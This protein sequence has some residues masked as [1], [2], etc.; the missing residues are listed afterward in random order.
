MINAQRIAAAVGAALAPLALF[1]CAS[2]ESFDEAIPPAVLAAD[3]NIVDT[4]LTLT[5]GPGGRGVGLRIYVSDTADAAVADSIHAALDAAFHASPSRPTG[6]I[7]DVAQAPRPDDV[8]LNVGRLSLDGVKPL[9]DLPGT[10][11]NDRVT[12]SSDELDTAF[13]SWEEQR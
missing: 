4:Y 6:I 2:Q 1:G 11:I 7:L 10:V 3:P 5:S 12:L 9:L 13:G 8:N